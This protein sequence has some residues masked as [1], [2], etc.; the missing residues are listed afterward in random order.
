MASSNDHNQE[1]KQTTIT[2]NLC[3]VCED[4]SPKMNYG[5][6]SCSSCRTFFRRN[7][8]PSKK[9]ITCRYDGH[10]EVNMLT[11]KV[12]AACRLTKCLAIGMNPDHIRKQ[13][14]SKKKE[15]S[16]K[17][18]SKQLDVVT[19]PEQSALNLSYGAGHFTLNPSDWKVISNVIHAFD[20]FNPV[21]EVRQTMTMSTTI[22]SSSSSSSSIVLPYGVPPS[23]HLMSSFYKS[24]Q[25]FIS[26]IPDFRILTTTEQSSLF[27]RNMFGLLCI[28]GMYFMRELGVF[29]RPEN[30]MMISPFYGND[31]F[32]QAKLI[33]QQLN[34]DPIVFKLLLVALAFSSNCSMLN[35]GTDIDR[36]SL[37]LGTFR[38]FGSQNVYIEL[39]WKYLLHT[40]GHEYSVQRFS[41]VVKQFLDVLRFS[42]EMYENNRLHQNFIDHTIGQ[43][44]RS[45]SGTDNNSIPLWGKK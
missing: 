42:F 38:L 25:S 33:C 31:V 37:L 28:G 32:Q 12:C 27:Q 26:S 36:D 44:Q 11:R 15:K 3:L 1:K 5:A 18:K 40:Y 35:N 24:L 10:C 29:D 16:Q 4:H 30:E 8:F 2:M 23:F 34:C 9:P 41:T 19:I 7:G 13:D 21:S 17:V 22:S 45:L 6:I 14:L 20:T 39:L 43:I